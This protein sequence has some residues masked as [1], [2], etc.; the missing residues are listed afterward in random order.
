MLD[1]MLFRIP[2]NKKMMLSKSVPSEISVHPNDNN[3]I[4]SF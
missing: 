2:E 4:V 1:E 3:N